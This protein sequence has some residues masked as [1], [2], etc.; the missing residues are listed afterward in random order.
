MTRFQTYGPRAAE[1][2]ARARSLD[3]NNPRI[4]MLEGQDKLFTPEQFGGSRAEAR[5]LFETSLKK[6]NEYKP[7]SS[8]HPNWGRSQVQYFLGQLK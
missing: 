2:L 7:Q 5:N 4:Y 1:A 8:I 6:F 3:P